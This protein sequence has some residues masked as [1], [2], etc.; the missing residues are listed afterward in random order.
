[1]GIQTRSFGNNL[2]LPDCVPLQ[3][4]EY[5]SDRGVSWTEAWGKYNKARAE[6]RTAFWLRSKKSM[7]GTDQIKCQVALAISLVA[8]FGRSQMFLLIK[9]H[10]GH[11]PKPHR[12]MDL[13]GW[14]AGMYNPVAVAKLEEEGLTRDW[15]WFH[16]KYEHKC[17]HAV[18]NKYCDGPDCGWGRRKR[19]SYV[20]TGSVISYWDIVDKCLPGKGKLKIIRVTTPDERIVGIHVEGKGL[21]QKIKASTPVG[22]WGS[23]LALAAAAAVAAVAA[24]AA[25]GAG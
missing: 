20:L 10:V 15:G 1:M 17:M 16:R 4:V 6:G 14:S 9:P 19:K 12:L 11:Y 7:Y 25:V 23:R 22:V 3:F 24:A 2:G 21:G 13:T 18:G 8:T 5:T